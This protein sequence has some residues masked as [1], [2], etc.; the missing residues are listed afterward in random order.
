MWKKKTKLLSNKQTKRRL[1][2][3]D[4]TNLDAT[5]KI[6]QTKLLTLGFFFVCFFTA[7]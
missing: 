2:K 5:H 1:T 4:T 3:N 6:H 7:L